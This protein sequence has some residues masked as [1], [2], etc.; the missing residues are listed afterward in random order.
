[1]T[2]RE[3]FI[4]V[5][6]YEKPDALPILFLEP[7][8]TYTIDRWME[9][10]LPE[11]VSPEVFLGADSFHRLPVS[12]T[13]R[14]VFEESVIEEDDT[15]IIKY[16]FMGS[17]VK[18]RKD[19]PSMYYGHIDHPVKNRD[20]WLMYKERYQL[21][22]RRYA[23]SI[24][25]MKKQADES[26]KPVALVPFPFFM[27][28][29][30]YT[31]GLENFLTAFYDDPD[32]I[33]EMFS[34]WADF[35]IDVMKPVLDKITPDVVPFGEDL[36]FKNGPHISPSIYKEFWLPYQNKV[37]KVLREAGVKNICMY[38]S[39]DFRPLI[40]IMLDNGI[41]LTWPLDQISGIDPYSLRKEYGKAL[42]MAGGISKETLT[43]GADAIDRRI[44]ELLPLIFEGGFFPA[45]DDMIPPEV[46]LEN[47]VYYINR[48]KEIKF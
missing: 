45:P 2:V 24:D 8:E 37:I 13:A 18:R 3:R 7:F 20:D 14:P 22:P 9:Q 36:A 16:D 48:L 10:G 26:D 40:P 38:T 42:R 43:D 11:N 5:L 21:C 4:K 47:V 19:A 15:Y 12:F 1:M 46:P 34:D 25:E 44:D 29:G 30:F 6:N 33:H 35:V 39:G 27:R 28:L 17:T 41:N 23:V 32:L 31:M